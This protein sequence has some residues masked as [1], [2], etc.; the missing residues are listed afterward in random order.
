M[1]RGENIN[2]R[3]IRPDEIE[4]FIQNTNDL[5]IRGNHLN[6]MLKN[7][8]QIRKG[9]METGFATE[10]WSVFLIVDKFDKPL[11]GISYFTVGPYAPIREFGYSLWDKEQRGKG[12]MTEAVKMLSDYL[13]LNSTL[14][15]IEIKMSVENRPSEKVAINAGFTKEGISREVIFNNGKY[16]DLFNYALLRKEWLEMRKR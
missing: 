10:D 11:G 4:L 7:P 12:Y 2:L 1:I 6:G 5:D 8:A 16:D 13:F 15:R 3:H 9:F 14:N